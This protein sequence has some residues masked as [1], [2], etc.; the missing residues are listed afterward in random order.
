[1]ALELNTLEDVFVN[2]GLQD[3][4]DE[5]LNP[6]S[7]LSNSSV[8]HESIPMPSSVNQRIYLPL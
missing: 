8:D 5:S 1:V 7:T 6:A 3:E 4:A 2:I